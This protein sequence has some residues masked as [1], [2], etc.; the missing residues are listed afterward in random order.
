MSHGLTNAS[1]YDRL[2]EDDAFFRGEDHFGTRPSRQLRDHLAAGGGMVE[3]LADRMSPEALERSRV[4]GL[5]FA[6]FMDCLFE[7]RPYSLI[8]VPQPPRFDWAAAKQESLARHD[9]QEAA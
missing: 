5:L 6:A 9:A 2:Y 1:P 8:P 4:G 3:Y 7:R